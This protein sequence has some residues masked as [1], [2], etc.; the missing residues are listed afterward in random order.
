MRPLAGDD[1]VVVDLAVQ[2]SDLK[3]CRLWCG[4]CRWIQRK[5]AFFTLGVMQV[6]ASGYLVGP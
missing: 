2:I 6:P 5:F 4:C 3:I 1:S